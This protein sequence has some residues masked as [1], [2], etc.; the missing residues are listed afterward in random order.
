MSDRWVS[1]V[2]RKDLSRDPIAR[3]YRLAVK[4]L[5]QRLHTLGGIQLMSDVADRVADLRPSHSSRRLAIV[6]AA[7][8]AIGQW[9]S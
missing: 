5:G 9:V 1:E 6:D 8:N 3:S 2:A 7:F 4:K